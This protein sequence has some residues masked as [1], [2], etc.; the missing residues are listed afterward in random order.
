MLKPSV[1]IYCGML[2]PSV[3]IY[4]GILFLQYDRCLEFFFKIQVAFVVVISSLCLWI[5]KIF[6][7]LVFT[8]IEAD[9][10]RFRKELL[11]CSY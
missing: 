3:I 2:K 7:I 6:E 5:L 10:M 9:I 4:C 1:I 8:L 11:F